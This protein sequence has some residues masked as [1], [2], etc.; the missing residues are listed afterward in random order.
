M[1]SLILNSQFTYNPGE[2]VKAASPGTEL[3]VF[4]VAAALDFSASGDPEALDATDTLDTYD[5]SEGDLVF[6]WGCTGGVGVDGVYTVGAE[7]SVQYKSITQLYTEG[8]RC[9][10]VAN[11][12][13]NGSTY[14]E[15]DSEYAVTTVS[16]PDFTT[17][18]VNVLHAI[19]AYN[20]GASDCYLQVHDAVGTPAEGRVPEI[21]IPLAAGG[22]GVFDFA[23]CGRKM[24]SGGLYVCGSSTDDTKTLIGAADLLIDITY[25]K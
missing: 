5:L 22:Y 24:N 23:A 17:Q 16:G 10:Y 2:K 8:Y 13:V 20:S 18:T 3:V 1:S 7:G 11:G 4:N 15:I 25:S 12:N 19:I 6:L 9:L 14:L 21:S